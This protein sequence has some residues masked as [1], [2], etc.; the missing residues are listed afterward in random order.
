MIS[1]VYMKQTVFSGIQPTGILHLGNYFGAIKQWITLQED[2]NC[3]FCIVDLHAITV[4][5]DPRKLHEQIY[6]IAATYLAAGLDPEKV[7]MF[8]QS[9]VPAHSEGAWL[10][11]TMAYMGELSRMTQYKEK[12]SNQDNVS[13][14]LFDYP[15]LMA[16]DILLY[17]TALVPVGEDQKQHVELAR[18]IAIRFNGRFGETFTVPEPLL[19]KVG[20]RIMGLDDPTKKMSKSASSEANYIALTDTPEV[21][22]KKILKAVTDS[23]AEIKFDP[24]AKPAISN[25]LTIYS[26]TTDIPIPQLEQ[27]YAGKNYGEFKQDLAEAVAKFLLDFQTKLT[28]QTNE[29]IQAILKNGAES[30]S[31]IAAKKIQDIHQKMGIGII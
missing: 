12:K 8:V 5:Q 20:A 13:V 30:A 31:P 10:L 28:A 22:K 6:Q 4:P 9:S 25:L 15:V 21:A 18:D 11:N 19:P 29:K 2:Y 1:L 7:T 16:A 27:Q 14:G 24:K 3:Y 23:G 26:L 17:D